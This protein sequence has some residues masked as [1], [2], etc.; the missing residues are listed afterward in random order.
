M[1]ALT[2]R[3]PWAWA[4]FHGKPI[5]NRDWSTRYRGE[6]V[7]HAAKGMTREEYRDALH[8]FPPTTAEPPSFDMLVRG[9]V[10]GVVRMVGCAADHPSPWFVGA[11]GFIFVEARLLPTPVPCAGALSFWDV[12]AEVEARI[13]AQL[14]ATS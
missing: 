13:R 6:L 14:N 4:L 2:V 12:P 10:I 5:E 9:A 7:I 11:Y 1:K 8:F 3:Q